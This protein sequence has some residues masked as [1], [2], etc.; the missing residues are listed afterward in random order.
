MRSFSLAAFTLLL[1]ATVAAPVQAHD[2]VFFNVGIG[3]CWGPA[4]GW[5]RY[6]YYN[7]YYYSPPAI[8]VPPSV[9]YAPPP[10]TTY[11]VPQESTPYVAPQ[12]YIAPQASAPAPAA[13][14][15][16]PV[17]INADQ[18]SPTFTDSFGRT[19]RHFQA[20]PDISGIACQQTDG[21]W[22]VVQ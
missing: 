4:W 14:P 22:K 12:A 1:M 8:Y 18:A 10:A 3:C 20:G 9:V 13:A 2:H 11:I 7:P 5:G 15:T 19:C 6:P 17:S 16:A 21:T